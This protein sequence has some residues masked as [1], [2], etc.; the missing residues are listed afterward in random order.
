[1]V[2]AKKEKDQPSLE[3]VQELFSAWRNQ[4]GRRDPIPPALWEQAVHLVAQYSV[5][6]I[7]KR[8]K[9]NYNELKIRA[10]GCPVTS[11]HKKRSPAFIELATLSTVECTIEMEKPGKKMKMCVRGASVNLLEISRQFWHP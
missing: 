5:N 3:E 4:K 10:G 1:M 8:L 2:P 9:L 7:A 6:A 11:V